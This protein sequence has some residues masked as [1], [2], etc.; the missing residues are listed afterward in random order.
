MNPYIKIALQAILKIFIDIIF[1]YSFG[2][3]RSYAISFKN[4]RIIDKNTDF[5]S[6]MYLDLL[7]WLNSLFFKNIVILKKFGLLTQMS[8]IFPIKLG[9]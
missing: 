6:K 9:C 2:H 7:S 8:L 5:Q 4:Y 1:F 3:H